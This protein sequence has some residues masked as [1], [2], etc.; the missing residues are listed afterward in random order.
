MN[1][2]LLKHG[3]EYKIDEPLS[4]HSSFKIGGNADIA[5]FPE[6]EQEL[7]LALEACALRGIK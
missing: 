1:E 4:K 6:N 2:Y 5:I 7:A 3:I